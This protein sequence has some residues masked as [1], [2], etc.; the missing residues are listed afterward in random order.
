MLQATHIVQLQSDAT[1]RWHTPATPEPAPAS[2]WDDLILAQHRANF[3]LWHHEDAARDPQ[4]TGDTI[5]QHKHAIDTLNQ[6]RN[7]L[8]EKMD[9]TLLAQAPPAA[10]TVP[11]HSETPGMMIDRLSILALKRFHTA[12]EFHRADATDAHRQ[13]NRDRL[14]ILDQQIAD[15]A[16]CLNDLWTGVLAG[17]R[18]IKLY[19]QMKMYND[20]ELNPILYRKTSVGDATTNES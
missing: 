18:R 20:P 9:V 1:A 10:D 6:C 3:D 16:Q 7:D 19:R 15:L 12:E 4:A 11:L 13:R 5:A 8:A 2:A 17:R 14:S